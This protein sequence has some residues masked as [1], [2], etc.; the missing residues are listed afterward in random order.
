VL[1]YVT[2]VK[3]PKDE[4]FEACTE[5]TNEAWGDEITFIPADQIAMVDYRRKRR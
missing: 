3:G 5:L 4:D 2:H 1:M